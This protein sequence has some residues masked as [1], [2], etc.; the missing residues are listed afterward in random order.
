MNQEGFDEL[1][2]ALAA[3]VS[4]G[5]VLKLAGAAILGGTLNFFA[6][7]E[8]AAARHRRRHRHRKPCGGNCC[9]GT[10][11]PC[12]PGQ[13]KCPPGQECSPVKTSHG[14][15]WGCLPRGAVS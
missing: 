4:R 10:T 14:G 12:V 6:L 1:T 11:R 2:K 9:N 7:P 3:S 15:G 13:C 5:Q 8:K